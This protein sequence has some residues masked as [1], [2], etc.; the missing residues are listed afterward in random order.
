MAVVV[1]V[2]REHRLSNVRR[3]AIRFRGGSAV[4]RS[5]SLENCPGDCDVHQ[6]VPGGAVARVRILPKILA[7]AGSASLR[8]AIIHN[9]THF[10]AILHM[11]LVALFALA[12]V[13]LLP[14]HAGAV[15][16][17]A[18][19]DAVVDRYA[20]R[21]L[22][23]NAF[24]RALQRVKLGSQVGGA[25]KTVPVFTF[26]SQSLRKVYV[27]RLRDAQSCLEDLWRL[28]ADDWLA[29]LV[30]HV[31]RH[32]SLTRGIE[33]PNTCR[34]AIHCV[35]CLA[36]NSARRAKSHIPVLVPSPLDLRQGATIQRPTRGDDLVIPGRVALG[37][38]PLLLWVSRVN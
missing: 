1:N 21:N 29:K 34:F 14:V 32:V 25:I 20:R 16:A 11:H 17:A 5:A 28:A 18:V 38:K 27:S 35:A 7:D 10:L 13:V 23:K 33:L 4:L 22:R 9:T 30:G 19:P 12:V 3:S 15:R 8:P 26:V 2:L 24:R 37:A 6:L 31:Q 36:D